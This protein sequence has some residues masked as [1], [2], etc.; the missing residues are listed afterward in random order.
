MYKRSK[1]NKHL[2]GLINLMDFLNQIWSKFLKY[3][4]ERVKL[5]RLKQ[6]AAAAFNIQLKAAV[7]VLHYLQGILN[8]NGD[9]V[10]T[11]QRREIRRYLT[12]FFGKLLNKRAI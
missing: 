9:S 8:R 4:D 7:K 12:F 10:E 11:R 2:I 3:R 1:T 5:K 6:L